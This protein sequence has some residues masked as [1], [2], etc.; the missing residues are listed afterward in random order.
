MNSTRIAFFSLLVLSW[1][2]CKPESGNISLEGQGNA[3]QLTLFRSDTFSVYAS[4]V[5]EDSL[6]GNGLSYALI[7][8]MNDPALGPSRASLFA[9]ISLIEPNSDFP[10]SKNPDSAVLFIPVVEGLNFYGNRS[11]EQVL[12]VYP[13]LEDIESGKTYYQH[14]AP[15]YD[16][17]VYSEYRGTLFSLYRDSLPYRKTKLAPESGLRIT[18]SPEMAKKLM[19]LPKSAYTTN[20]EL[21][22]YFPGIAIVPQNTDM[23]PGAGGFGVFDMHT[24]GSLAYRAKILLYYD[25]TST[26]VFGFDGK[27]QTTTA[28]Q[29]GPHPSA[30]TQQTL[31]PNAHYNQTYVQALGGLKTWL[32]FPS[33]YSLI[34]DGNVAIN[35]AELVLQTSSGFSTSNSFYSAPRLNLFQPLSIGQDPNSGELTFFSDRNALIEDG[36]SAGFGGIYNESNQT[37]RFIITRHFQNLLNRSWFD[38]ID[39]NGGLYL[40]VPSDQP[41]LGARSILDHSKTKLIITYTKPN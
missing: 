37:Y 33:I 27:T 31:N 1:V 20:D 29:I 8:A 18:L 28:G 17:S 35:K 7:G 30:V 36:T 9:S 11:T 34:Q 15:S 41:V 2:A 19:S 3:N 6:P 39:Y 21:A 24:I 10:N 22:K 32:R 13:L 38:S 16:A 26:F 4:T 5:R 23:A 25:D 12:R 14:I 40:C